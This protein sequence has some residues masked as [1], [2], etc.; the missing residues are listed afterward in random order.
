VTDQFELARTVGSPN[1][2]LVVVDADRQARMAT[3]AALVRRFEPD[4]RVVTADSPTTGL[5][6]LEGLASDGED[7]ALIAADL[8]LPGM[9]GLDSWSRP[10]RCT[11]VPA[12]CC[13]WRWIVTTR[14]F[15]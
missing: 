4:F 2:V 9:D 3:E 11:E 14:G 8:R 10:M 12:A 5:A 13:C 6:A 15:L 7:V 1:P